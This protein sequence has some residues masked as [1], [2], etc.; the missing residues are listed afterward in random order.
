[1]AFLQRYPKQRRRCCVLGLSIVTLALIVS[2]FSTH[3]W[4]L[5]LTQGILYAIGGSMFHT[6][7]IVFLDEWFITRKGFAFGVMWAGT[8]VSGICIP[9]LMNWGL[10]KYS[11]PTMLRVWALS[12]LLLSG[13]LLC[14]VKPRIPVSVAAHPRR[15]DFNF[16]RTRTF[17]T[18]QTGNI[19]ESLGFF[20]PNIYLPTYARSLGLSPVAGT[21]LV[22][23]FNA[24][25]V[26]GQVTLGTLS[27][28]V[29][30]TSVIL[31]STIGTTLSVFL[32]WGLSASLPLLSIFSIAYGLF[33]GGF[34]S[35]WTGCMREVKK[36]D[37]R[38][39][40]GLVFGLLSAGRGIGS[41]VAGPMSEA[42]LNEKPWIGEA[43]AGYGSGYGGLIVFTGMSAMLGGVSWV[44]RRINWI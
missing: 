35:T 2:S 41:V 27:D 44:S 20:I 3:V 28:H 24:T 37:R 6:P 14:F 16:L 13:P 40:M 23:L 8:G 38:A 18:L 30:V 29:H 25:S 33:A 7:T 9:L 5:I 21:L 34:S 15:L 19:L 4:H 31:I 1:M 26:F 32:L 39:E 17:W 42:L 10:N 43:A 22:S 11:Y 36:V 12:L